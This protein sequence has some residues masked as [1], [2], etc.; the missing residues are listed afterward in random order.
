VLTRDIDL[1]LLE[2]GTQ[3]KIKNEFDRLFAGSVT[4]HTDGSIV[5]SPDG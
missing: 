2:S 5:V 4:N 3:E 1:N